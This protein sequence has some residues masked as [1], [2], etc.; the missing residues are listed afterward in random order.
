[1]NKKEKDKIEFI[2]TCK[3][4]NFRNELVMSK[5]NLEKINPRHCMN[6]GHKTTYSKKPFAL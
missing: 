6:C 3:T 5:E 4:C 1:M 2:S